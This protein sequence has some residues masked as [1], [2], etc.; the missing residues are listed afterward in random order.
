LGVPL[1]ALTK[2]NPSRLAL[3]NLP[4]FSPVATKLMTLL[5][6]E[7]S[8]FK[9]AADLLKSDAAL[10]AEVLRLANSPSAG[11]RFPT[12]SVL[13]ALSV[14]GVNR[15][16]S[17]AV[18]LCVGRL[19]KPVAKL[20]LMR[21][22][23]RHNLATALIASEWSADYRVDGEKAYTFGLLAGLGRLAL[24]ASDPEVYSRLA[25]RAQIEN[26]PLEMLENRFYGF[27]H[28]DAGRWLVT[29]WRLP[30]EL[31][32]VL[33]GSPTDG[34]NADLA[35]LIRE[36]GSEANRLGFGVLEN[37]AP[38]TPDNLSFE[39]AERVNQVEQDLGI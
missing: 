38:A 2:P 31:T 37:P 33:T 26:M 5:R 21:R 1:S 24:L 25:E 29:E 10:T 36:A 23:W 8:S 16:A 4:P 3:R 19:L 34:P 28:R 11:L 9:D 27:D 14:L 6:Q 22:C 20:P 13:Q 18:T 35:L 15:I 7:N 30:A 12:T 32:D 17:L 39:I